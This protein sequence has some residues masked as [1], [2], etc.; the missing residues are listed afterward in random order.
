[1]S[2]TPQRQPVSTG[3]WFVIWFGLGVFWNIWGAY[4][5]WWGV[6]YGLWWPTWV[7]YW[8]AGMLLL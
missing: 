1:M 6:L 3:A 2:D 7:G 8:L 4:G 5:F